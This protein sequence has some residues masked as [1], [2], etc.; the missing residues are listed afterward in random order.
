MSGRLKV[1][2][3]LLALWSGANLALA[4]GILLSMA[5]GRPPP[6]TRY[7]LVDNNTSLDP[8]FLALLQSVA[9]LANGAIAAL[10]GLVLA[11]TFRS[12]SHGRRWSWWSVA[13]STLFMQVLGFLADLPLGHA[14]LLANLVSLGILGVAL[15][16]S[17]PYLGRREPGSDERTPRSHR[18][19]HRKRREE[20][21]S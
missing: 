7:L 11:V 8:A 21:S 9:T 13:M 6:A 15:G 17:C 18:R 1:G 2:V 10:C 16:A 4:L 5:M 3:I 14:N 12:L 19:R 20:D